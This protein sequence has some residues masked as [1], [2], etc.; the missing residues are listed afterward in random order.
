MEISWK[1]FLTDSKKGTLR[2][3]GVPYGLAI[4]NDSQCIGWF[5]GAMVEISREELLPSTV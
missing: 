1:S 2:D 4:K 5:S 3:Y